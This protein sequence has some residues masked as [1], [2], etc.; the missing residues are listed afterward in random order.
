MRNIIS[1]RNFQYKLKVL[2]KAIN[3][4]LVIADSVI[5]YYHSLISYAALY[6]Q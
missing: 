1:V 4:V 6:N 5:S 2:G 3:M